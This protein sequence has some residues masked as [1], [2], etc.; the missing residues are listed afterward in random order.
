ME[1][2]ALTFKLEWGP[3]A[4]TKD[5]GQNIPNIEFDQI[6]QKPTEDFC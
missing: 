6:R 4:D 2:P 1:F 5:K 3:L